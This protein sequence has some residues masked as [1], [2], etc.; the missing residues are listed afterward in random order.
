M[1]RS[2]LL[3]P[4]LQTIWRILPT[5]LKENRGLSVWNAAKPVKD[6]LLKVLIKHQQ[7]RWQ[8]LVKKA[9]QVA[10]AAK[11]IIKTVV[12][13]LTPVKISSPQSLLALVPHLLW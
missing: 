13:K 12:H 3:L 4:C 11:T 1:Q 6:M 10:N 2:P 9:D 5:L 7:H 8:G